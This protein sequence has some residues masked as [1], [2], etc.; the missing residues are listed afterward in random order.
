MARS[1]HA[2]L[3]Y[4][5]HFPD[6]VIILAVRWYLRYS[7]SYRDLEEILSERGVLVDHSTIWRWIQCYA[8]ELER[9]V[10]RAVKPTGTQW[11]VDE[12]YVRVAGQWTYLYRAVDAQGAMVDFYL[13]KTRD[14]AAAKLF[15]RKALSEPGRVLP[16]VVRVDG[17]ITYPIAI[18][19]LQ[20]D[21]L[22][23][24][25]CQC[26]GCAPGE[27]NRIEQDHR[28]IQRRADAKQY[29]RSWIGARNTIAGCEAMHM[30]RKGQ[31]PG[32]E[33]GDS[34]AQA[35]WVYCVLKQ[36]A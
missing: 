12:T 5:R 17:N 21:G 23:P 33:R 8:P 31:V 25:S 6:D 27:N 19:A 22:L 1:P 10:H 26:V 32:C 24:N 28:G 13:S 36:A 14:E 30:L 7:L 35:Q 9:R 29:F 11:H 4:G 3:F 34:V 18:R 2:P 16:E 15:F 20:R